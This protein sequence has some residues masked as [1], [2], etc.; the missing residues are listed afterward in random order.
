LANS[1]D[2]YFCDDEFY[3]NLYAT[4]VYFGALLG[5]ITI[6]FLADN[7]GRRKVV[8]FSWGVGTLGTII[9]LASQGILM[10]SMGL[11]LAGF[12]TDAI[13]GVTYSV[14]V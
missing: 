5:Y 4:G 12:G 6:N 7:Y 10:A 14:M 3:L 8:L 11:F 1:F 2:P 9:L 13:L